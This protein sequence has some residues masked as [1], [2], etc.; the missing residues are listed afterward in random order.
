MVEP[1]FDAPTSCFR[2]MLKYLPVFFVICNIAGL[3]TIYMVYHIMPMINSHS[4]Y[5][6]AIVETV[7]FNVVTVFVFLNYI[8]CLLVHPGAIPDQE[9]GDIDAYMDY[10]NLNLLQSKRSGE[11]RHCKWCGKFKPDRCHHCRVCRMCILKMDHHC[12]WIYNCVGFRNH[13]YFFLLLFYSLLDCMFI[14]W[15]MSSSVK[16]VTPYTPF[17]SMFMLLFGVSLA[18]FLGALLACFFSF[19]VW[20][21]AQALTTI[22]FCEKTVKNSTSSPFDHGIFENI[23]DVLGDNPLLWLF[24]IYRPAGEGLS[25][26]TEKT[27]LQGSPRR[28][29]KSFHA[30]APGGKYASDSASDGSEESERSP[31]SQPVTAP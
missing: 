9:P 16:G 30:E 21:M 13:K 26:L 28:Q 31:V 2:D 29:K 5:H 6:R 14:V 23:C 7:I 27:R 10:R 19:H 12:P 15:T 4:H 18:G 1:G 22:E 24:P 8:L 20:L 3:Y 17:I 25:F 11:R